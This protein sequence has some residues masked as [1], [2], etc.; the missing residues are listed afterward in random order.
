VMGPT[1]PNRFHLHLGTSQ[2]QQG[3]DWLS[4]QYSS[5]DA[6]DAKGV[7]RRYYYFG[8]P[9]IT[10]YSARL[11]SP[12]A[13]MGPVFFDDVAA[14]NLPQVSY[15]DPVLSFFN[16]VGNDDHPPADVRDGQAFVASIY[17]AIANS[18]YWGRTM[19]IVTYDEHGGY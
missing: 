3:N 4:D 10:T 16:V 12:W 9:V 15:V 13:K 2:G 11:H 17:D 14:G 1:W 6:L 19:I 7:T 8:L 18:D 5:F